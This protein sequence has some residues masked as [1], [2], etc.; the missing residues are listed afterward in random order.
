MDIIYNLLMF[1]V[2][3]IMVGYITYFIGFD[4]GV[5]SIRP[6]QP[7]LTKKEKTFCELL[8]TG[9]IARDESGSLYYYSRYK[10]TK[11]IKCASWELSGDNYSE[12]YHRITYDDLLEYLGYNIKFSFIT[13]EDEE[14]WRVEDLLKLRVED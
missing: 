3:G 8:E 2:G 14:P 13:W 4:K 5:D 7:V 10:P 6:N 1:I 12:D 11:N 9:Y